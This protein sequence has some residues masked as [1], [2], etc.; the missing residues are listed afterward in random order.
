[1]GP[2]GSMQ[3]FEVVEVEEVS[4]VCSALTAYQ[5]EHETDWISE[6]CAE[7]TV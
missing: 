6:N 4:E 5:S 2:L 7:N 1:M 3:T